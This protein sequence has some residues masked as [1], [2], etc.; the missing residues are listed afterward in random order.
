MTGVGNGRHTRTSSWPNLAPRMTAPWA[1]LAVLLAASP[2]LAQSPVRAEDSVQ[3][4]GTV[5]TNREDTDKRPGRMRL[6]LDDTVLSPTLA[7]RLAFSAALDQRDDSP[8]AWGDGAGGYGKRLAG[9][10]GLA[11]S[12]LGVQHGTAALLKLDPK[13]DRTR[14]GCKNPFKRAGY[15]ASRALF[16]RDARGRAVP[17]VPV[18]AGAAGG[19]LIA[20]AWYPKNEGPGHDAARFAAMSLVGQ[21]GANVFR[22]FS[23]ELK[24]LIKRGKPKPSNEPRPATTP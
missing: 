13:G 2:G 14:C 7:P 9:R 11:M 10:A 8:S 3:V 22:E 17:N 12:Q 15:A 4:E 1:A 21:A 18:V 24:R 6:F 5:P 23:P 20:R 19:A 16:T